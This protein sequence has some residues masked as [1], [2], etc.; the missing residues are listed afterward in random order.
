VN[1][2]VKG[3]CE[4]L[5]PRVVL[6]L[7]TFNTALA[8]PSSER[9]C[10]VPVAD[11]KP[12]AADLGDTWRITL[13]SH[14]IADVPYLFFTP[15]NRSGTWYINDDRRLVS[16]DTPFPRSYFDENGWVKE[17]WSGRVV[18]VTQLNNPKVSV[19][20]KGLGL[21]TPFS[22]PKGIEGRNVNGPYLLPN[23]QQTIVVIDGQF[24]IV[25]ETALSLWQES[26]KLNAAGIDF[27]H[28]HYS[29]ELRGLIVLKPSRD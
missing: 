17:S 10:I 19:F 23:T 11:G 18:A 29:P 15:N 25:G 13:N 4:W 9:F 28:L 1:A 16:S 21:F 20:D 22:L 24:Y 2:D 8:T 27:A 12:T 26:S 3:I 6:C 7:L 5:A 14:R